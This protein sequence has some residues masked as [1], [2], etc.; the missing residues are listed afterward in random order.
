MAIEYSYKIFCFEALS[1][2]HCGAFGQNF[3]SRLIKSVINIIPYLYQQ[4]LVGSSSVLPKLERCD[5]N[6]FIFFRVLKCDF[7]FAAV[8][9]FILAALF[10]TVFFFFLFVCSYNCEL[11]QALV[12]F[13]A[14]M[15]VC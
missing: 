6:M 14:W 5:T 13:A 1:K 9:A 7:S 4:S 12:I 11:Y 10:S 3:I 8:E 2:P 15:Y